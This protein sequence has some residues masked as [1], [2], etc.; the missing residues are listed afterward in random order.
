[1]NKTIHKYFNPYL[2]L[3]ALGIFRL[4]LGTLLILDL[5]INKWPFLEA[6]YTDTGVLSQ[7]ILD[8]IIS[9]DPSREMYR[10]GL[11]Q[12][13]DSVNAVSFFFI[14]TLASYIL[15][16]IGFRSKIF[17]ILSFI[18]LWSIHQ[19][20]GLILS[21]PDEI[22]INLL[23]IAMFLP[24]DQR[25]SFF[26]VGNQI[27]NNQHK[28]FAT[29]YF[30]FFIGM[31]YFYQAFLK[32]GN[33][34][35]NGDALSYALMEKIWT[36]P[37]ATSLL[38][39]P[40][41]CHF[42]SSFT[43]LIE[44]SIICLLFF[45]LLNKWTRLLSVILLLGVHWTIF[46]FLDLGLFPIIVPTFAVLL[47][48]S[49]VWD[50][51]GRKLNNWKSKRKSIEQSE[52]L[53]GLQKKLKPL[54]IV[55]LGIVFVLVVWRSALSSESFITYL[56][57]PTFVKKLNHTSLFFQYW[58]FYSPNPSI[59]HG[60]FKVVG[61]R[62]NGQEIDLRTGKKI[63]MNDTNLQS[64]RNYSWLVFY[65]KT[66]LYNYISSRELLNKW[67]DYEYQK[68]IRSYSYGEIAQ[69]RIIAFTETIL[70]PGKSTP[71]GN[72]IFSY[73]PMSK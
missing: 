52:L 39:Y 73:A 54:S 15:M 57:Q 62:S 29:F 9:S 65:Y 33:L 49:F 53:V 28:S 69:V 72:F 50:Y 20:N 51:L 63:T 64:Y 68:Y 42:L 47:I 59:T 61:V 2:D 38:E 1:L 34:W 10:W 36:K 46:L 23:F 66:I 55:L 37:L 3:R 19:R 22:M 30:L 32:T 21:G 43:L 12:F 17:T 11:L 70:A 6:F 31:V 13:F 18:A 41:L 25:F 4:F 60:W 58:G 5:L 27:V 26:R 14:L 67:S 16:T 7:G 71:T 40:E 45:P 56:P 24:L 44:Y 48:P 35:I 8:T